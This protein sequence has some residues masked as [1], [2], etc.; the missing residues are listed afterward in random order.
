MTS[1]SRQTSGLPAAQVYVIPA[2]ANYSN[3]AD[4]HNL[5]LN[6]T[7][8]ELGAYNPETGALYAGAIPVGSPYQF[9]QSRGVAG[10]KTIMSSAIFN[11]KTP[12][13]AIACGYEAGLTMTKSL[14]VSSGATDKDQH[15]GLTI[16]DTTETTQPEFTET[17]T[18]NS[19]TGTETAAQIAAG[20]Y[21]NWLVQKTIQANKGYGARSR[22]N[23]TLAGNVITITPLSQLTL[24]VAG[25]YDSDLSNGLI[26]DLTPWKKEEGSYA[27]VAQLE[28]EGNVFDEFKVGNYYNR[29]WNFG[30][31]YLYSSVG[32]TYDLIILKARQEELGRNHPFRSLIMTPMVVIAAQ[33]S[34][35]GVSGSAAFTALRTVLGV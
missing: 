35:A 19:K 8:G 14:T 32:C 16:L 9:Y 33:T 6:G 10:T 7:N 5:V 12:K 2:T 20:I 29:L 3:E 21:N 28:A 13:E 17:Y 11:Q 24:F 22:F 30:N 25:F 27:Q 4:I 31:P 23:L 15:F 1:Y 18:F 26:T 34:T